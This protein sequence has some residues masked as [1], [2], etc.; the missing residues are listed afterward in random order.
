MALTYDALSGVQVCA[1]NQI[2]LP[3]IF[4]KDSPLAGKMQAFSWLDA[5]SMRAERLHRVLPRWR[6]RNTCIYRGFGIGGLL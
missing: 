5:R 2:A 1:E 4:R 6:W 3:G